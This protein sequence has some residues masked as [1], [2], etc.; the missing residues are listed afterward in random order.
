MSSVPRELKGFHPTVPIWMSLSAGNVVPT[1]QLQWTAS[2][3]A[4]QCEEILRCDD[5]R[6]AYYDGI[7][8]DEVE[9]D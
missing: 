8:V 7:L 6:D 3:Q 9:N 2:S 4:A 5:C 1:E